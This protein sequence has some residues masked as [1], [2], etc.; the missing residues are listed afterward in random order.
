MGIDPLL[1]AYGDLY[2]SPHDAERL[3]VHIRAKKADERRDTE[4]AEAKAK[5]A[6]EATTAALDDQQRE[7]VQRRQRQKPPDTDKAE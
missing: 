6:A 2:V 3:T 4:K 7:S 5:A 1:D